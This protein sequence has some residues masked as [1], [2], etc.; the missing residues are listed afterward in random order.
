MLR[1]EATTR[2][3]VFGEL[4]AMRQLSHKYRS[5]LYNGLAVL[6]ERETFNKHVAY[7][8]QERRYQ[9]MAFRVFRNDALSR[10]RASFDNAARYTY[11]AARAYDYETNLDPTDRGSA[12]GILKDIMKARSIGVLDDGEPVAGSGGLADALARMDGNF[13]VLLGQLGLNQGQEE[14]SKDLPPL[15]VGSHSFE[16]RVR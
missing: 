4:V 15:G 10:Y 5:E 14:C 11:L 16:W 6:T 3:A 7:T 12:R 13:D 1:N 8:T 9:D 2:I